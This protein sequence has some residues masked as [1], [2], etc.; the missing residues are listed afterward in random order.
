[1]HNL[2]LCM[3]PYEREALAPFLLSKAEHAIA[4]S[5]I[6]QVAVGR[7]KVGLP[8]PN[9]LRVLSLRL[10]K[11]LSTGCSLREQGLYKP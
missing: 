11:K 10:S 3:R 5:S 8:N 1:M 9:R 4:K 7:P 6:L 2:R